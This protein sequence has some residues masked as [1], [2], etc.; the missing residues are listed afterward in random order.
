VAFQSA[1]APL[2]R[3]RWPIFATE[4]VAALAAC[5][6][7]RLADQVERLRIVEV[8]DCGDDFCQS[9]YT[10]PKPAG[11]YGSGH[12]TVCLDAPW[13]GYLILDV[14]HDDIVY[15]EVLYRSRLC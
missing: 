13:P 10:G 9:I 14:V 5:G 8:C 11:A 4:L 1:Q 15:V 6:E 3:T 12:R 7:D 2:L